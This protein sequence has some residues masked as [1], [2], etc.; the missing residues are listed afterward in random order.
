MSQGGSMPVDIE[1]SHSFSLRNYSQKGSHRNLE[2]TAGRLGE[3]LGE[4]SGLSNYSKAKAE[5]QQQSRQFAF[6]D[7]VMSSSGRQ[8]SKQNLGT[9]FSSTRT[10]P[11]HDRKRSANLEN[12][13][14]A[15]GVASLRVDQ[16]LEDTESMHS[17]RLATGTLDASMEEPGAPQ[18]VTDYGYAQP[19]PS[20]FNKYSSHHGSLPHTPT[21]GAAVARNSM[22]PV[23][24]KGGWAYTGS[25][26]P[27]NSAMPEIAESVVSRD[28]DDWEEADE[29]HG[30]G[31]SLNFDRK[32]HSSF[33][34]SH[35]DE[36]SRRR[37][38]EAMLRSAEQT[39]Q[40]HAEQPKRGSAHPV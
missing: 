6:V 3:R 33:M 11:F 13:A 23:T 28:E 20:P 2:G 39:P 18:P 36:L 8:A 15:A 37:Q 21:S 12:M 9:G 19:A 7:K 32:Y 1:A 30:I 5:A 10:K 27:Q 35:S 16:T 40:Q 4:L 22:P 26:D 14:L 24:G 25:E 29:V 17:A 34:V 31:T 38:N